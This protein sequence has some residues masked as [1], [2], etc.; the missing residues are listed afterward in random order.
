MPR[1]R[2]ALLG[3]S[4]FERSTLASCF[5]LAPERVPGYEQAAAVAAS[6]FIVA[7][8]DLAGVESELRQ[9]GRLADTVCVGPHPVPGAIGHVVR[10]LDPTL[11][12]RELDAL[13]SLRIGRVSRP[14]AP[15]PELNDSIQDPAS[16]ARH[17]ARA[18]ARSRAARRRSNEQPAGSPAATTLHA[19]VL[20]DSDIATQYLAHL[21][22]ELG[23]DVHRA[24]DS[25]SALDVLATQPIAI[26]FLD[27]VLAEGDELDGLDVCQRIKHAP[28]VMAGG[29]PLV[30]LVSGQARASDRVRATL[31]GA[32]AFLAKPFT[33]QQLVRTIESCGLSLLPTLSDAPGAPR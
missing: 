21:L 17:A 10:P 3:F 8:L 20:D 32:D 22:E 7:D 18:R 9:S 25:G 24:A 23:L 14:S 26:A 31:A 13:V 6:D 11:V 16:L 27:I 19:L 28:L 2:V 15:P 4:D 1:Y 29:T 30:V 33:Q 12:V 5:R